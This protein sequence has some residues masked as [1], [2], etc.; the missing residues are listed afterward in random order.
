MFDYI[1]KPIKLICY[2]IWNETLE[3][4]QFLTSRNIE[5]CSLLIELKE[6][7]YSVISAATRE[8]RSNR[9]KATNTNDQ[10]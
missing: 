2:E 6:K 8:V 1:A 9:S 4:N 3:L 5:N 7:T 10:I